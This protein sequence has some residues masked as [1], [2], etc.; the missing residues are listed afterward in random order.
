M[1]F[2][3]SS[4]TTLRN[5]IKKI[6]FFYLYGATFSFTLC[7]SHTLFTEEEE[8]E[9]EGEEKERFDTTIRGASRAITGEG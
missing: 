4:S 9:E 6:N 8:E 3:S 7:E 2:S 5:R 1:L